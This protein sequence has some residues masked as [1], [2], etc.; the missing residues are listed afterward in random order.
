MIYAIIYYINIEY[1]KIFQE[2]IFNLNQELNPW[3][4]A[5]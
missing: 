5:L 4:L 3:I 1:I 2:K